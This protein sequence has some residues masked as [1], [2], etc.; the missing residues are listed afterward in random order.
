MRH[1]FQQHQSNSR[2]TSQERDTRFG[3]Y[4]DRVGSGVELA[5]T[6]WRGGELVT[7]PTL[8]NK[9]L[10]GIRPKKF[11]YSPIGDGVV[12][13]DGVEMKRGP[14]DLTPKVEVIH[15]R[16]VEKGDAGQGGVRV[17][18]KAW[19]SGGGPGDNSALSQS[20]YSTNAPTPAPVGDIT[21][22]TPAPVAASQNASAAPTPTPYS[23]PASELLASLNATPTPSAAPAPAPAPSAPTHSY[24]APV[25]SLPSSAYNT[26]AS[27]PAT[28]PAYNPYG[29]YGSQ[30]SSAPY[31]SKFTFFILALFV[32]EI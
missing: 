1:S 17:T 30:R 23:A 6:H 12:A 3:G 8:V 14:V 16:V 31:D 2:A 7:D 10:N 26:L 25:S 29:T 18:E 5:P 24:A 13:A 19:S 9:V 32:L 28:E 22:S 21:R 11:F 20:A 27:A 15:Q 4:G